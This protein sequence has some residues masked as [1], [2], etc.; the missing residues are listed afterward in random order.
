[1]KQPKKRVYCLDVDT[2]EV[3]FSFDKEANIYFG[4]F[5]DFSE[6]PKHTPRGRPWVNVTYDGCPY[7]EEEYGDCGSCK[8]FRCEHPG[9][10]IGICENEYLRKED[11]TNEKS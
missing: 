6:T 9:D 5:P 11:L 3:K 1:M 2:V 7:A 8:Y 10:L 4:D